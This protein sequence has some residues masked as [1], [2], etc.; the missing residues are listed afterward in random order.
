LPELIKFN[1]RHAAD[2]N[3]YQLFAFHEPSAKTFADL[4]P[5]MAPLK[6]QHW[7]GKDLPMPILLD[8]SGETMKRYGISGFPTKILIDPQGRV[9]RGGNDK[10]LEEMLKKEK[11]R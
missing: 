8:A 11:A 2:R 7:G 3:R 6:E 1:E 10:V 9:V 5:K 4:D